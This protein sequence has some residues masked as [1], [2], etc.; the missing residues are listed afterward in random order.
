MKVV[1]KQIEMIAWF[2][3]TGVIQ[4]IKF[5][6]KGEK[7]LDKIIKI[8]KIVDQ[9]KEKIYGIPMILFKCQSIIDGIEMLYELKYEISNCKWYVY[10]F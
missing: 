5:R 3:N 8:D 1:N 9:S 6:Y 7:S 2:T 4:P 10:K